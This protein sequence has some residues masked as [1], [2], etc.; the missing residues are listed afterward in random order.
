MVDI[1]RISDS[2]YFL[3][4]VTFY[5]CSFPS[6]FVLFVGGSPTPDELRTAHQLSA[7]E[8]WVLR[9]SVVCVAFRHI[10]LWDDAFVLSRDLNK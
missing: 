3:R 6:L 5:L 10:S 2:Q 8:K 7:E 9:L 1:V 4:D